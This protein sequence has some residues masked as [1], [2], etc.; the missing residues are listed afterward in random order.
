MFH[1]TRCFT[2]KRVRSLW[3]PSP[4][5]CAWATQLAPFEEMLQP[6]QAVESAT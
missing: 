3:G 4:R 6:W 5:R 1:C 2:P